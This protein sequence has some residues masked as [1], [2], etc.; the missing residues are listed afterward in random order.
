MASPAHGRVEQIIRFGPFEMNPQTG[1]TRKHGIG[2]RL[3]GQ[4][5]QILVVLLERPGE[6]VSRDYLR[7]RLWTDD[8]FVEFENGLNNAVKKLRAALGDSGDRPLYVE[9]VPRVGY[10]FIAPVEKV[11]ARASLTPPPAERAEPTPASTRTET[12]PPPVHAERGPTEPKTRRADVLIRRRWYVVGLAALFVA[13]LAYLPRLRLR[14]RPVARRRMLVA[15]LPFENLTGNAAQDYFSD[16]LTEE[17]IAQLGPL[18]PQR[19]G[20]IARTSVM[21]YK[22]TQ[23]RLDQVGRELGVQYVL[24]GSVRRDADKVRITAELVQPADQTRLWSREYDRQVTDLLSLQSEIA[25]EIADEVELAVGGAGKIDTVRQP[26]LSPQEYEAYD[27]YL[28]GRYFLNKRTTEDLQKAIRCFEQAIERD[29]NAARAYSGLADSYALMSGYSGLALSN[30]VMPKAR[31]AALRALEI[32]DHS[33]E[34]HTSLALITENYDWDWQTAE[35]EYV[36]A[37]QL[38]ANY[39]T[40]H[41]WYAELLTWEGRFDEALRESERARQLDPLSLIIAADRGATLYFSR[42]YD[43]AIAQF[44]SVLEVEPEFPRACLVVN[45]Y[46]EKGQFANALA[47]IGRCR[48]TPYHEVWN[49]SLLAYVEGRSGQFVEARRALEHLEQL[50]KR[51]QVDPAAFVPPYIA[52]GKNDQAIAMLQK[53]YSHHSN[54]MT[55]LKVDPIYDPLRHDP[56]F[57]DL[58]RRVGLAE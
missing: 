4:P 19:L 29:S 3:G 42:R 45:A 22:H 41:Q 25:V 7:R 56:R 17:M 8:T 30:D 37:I 52:L 11:P 20:V 36:R 27:L 18:D 16:G 1:E 40:A 12:A 44:N 28:H 23:E 38:D 51:Q 31:A 26:V 58:L 14:G 24:E 10:R 50:S 54:Q 15:V 47:A 33:A 21:H 48:R 32:D 46:A 57:R 9:T 5:T 43:E 34:A 2:V 6:V 53:A 35:K 49:L 39:A 55:A 13:C